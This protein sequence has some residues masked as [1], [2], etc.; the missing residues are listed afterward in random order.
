MD[1]IHAW[2]YDRCCEPILC[3]MW[4]APAGYGLQWAA[5]QEALLLQGAGSE[6][7]RAD[8]L[9]GIRLAWGTEALPLGLRLG[10]EIALGG[11][12]EETLD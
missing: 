6:L 8:A 12:Q 11:R 3:H 5:E 7:D 1:N 2:L 10:L 4:N 9:T